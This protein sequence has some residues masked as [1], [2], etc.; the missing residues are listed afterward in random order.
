MSS[1]CSVDRQM[2]CTP[3]VCGNFSAYTKVSLMGYFICCWHVGEA[4]FF[5]IDGENNA[6]NLKQ[7]WDKG[8]AVPLPWSTLHVWIFQVC[9]WCGPCH[10]WNNAVAWGLSYNG[11]KFESR[12]FCLSVLEWSERGVELAPIVE[13]STSFLC[14]DGL[15]G[16]VE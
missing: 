10:A 1:C 8:N 6:R 5:F 14:L 2:V 7:C 11:W 16:Q 3:D 13:D 15:R 4:P 9:F 12:Y